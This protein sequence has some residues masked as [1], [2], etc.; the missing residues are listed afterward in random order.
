MSEF[1]DRVGFVEEGRIIQRRK[2]GPHDYRD[3]IS[4]G[5]GM[6]L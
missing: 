1:A 3:D 6:A 4:M 5:W 2:D